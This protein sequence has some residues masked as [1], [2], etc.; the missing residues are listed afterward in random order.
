MSLTSHLRD[1]ESPVRHFLEV[2]F[3]YA[4][5]TARLASPTAVANSTMPLAGQIN[6]PLSGTSIDYRIRYEFELTAVDQLVAYRGASL[7]MSGKSRHEFVAWHRNP[8]LMA[9]LH[10][11]ARMSSRLIAGFFAHLERFVLAVGLPGAALSKANE[12][13]LDRCCLILG[14]FEQFHRAGVERIW[15]SSIL[16]GAVDST[17]VDQLLGLVPAPWVEDL[18]ELAAGFKRSLGSHRAKNTICNPKF[19]GSR[20][21]GGADADLILDGKLCEIKTTIKPSIDPAWLFQLVAYALLDYEN[22]YDITA[23]GLYLTRQEQWVD[24][25]LDS[26]LGLLSGR[27]NVDV[28]DLR[29]RFREMVQSLPVVF[30]SRAPRRP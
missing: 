28:G 1:P 16:A 6:Y 7:L 14:C 22:Q 11:D 26:F 20:D 2:V 9:E 25:E 3:P 15:P 8:D 21:V 17:S 29:L 27:P 18:G 23:L 10:P 19:E 4:S 30:G 12:D 24:W 13:E 5:Q